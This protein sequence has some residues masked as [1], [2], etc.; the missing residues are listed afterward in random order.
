[1]GIC[2]LKCPFKFAGPWPMGVSDLKPHN[3]GFTFVD[4]RRFR[5]LGC[6]PF[7]PHGGPEGQEIEGSKGG[8]HL[9]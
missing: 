7:I 3:L 2:L 6:A 1:M 9:L 8:N 4:L 5:I